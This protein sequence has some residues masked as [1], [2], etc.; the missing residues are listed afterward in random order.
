[1]KFIAEFGMSNYDNIKLGPGFE[2]N[3]DKTSL[4]N[5]L[6]TRQAFI[7]E[8]LDLELA[9]RPASASIR[10]LR[11]EGVQSNMVVPLIMG[12]SVFGIVFFSSIHKHFFTQQHLKLSEKLIFEISGFMNRAY[13]TKV[14]LSRITSGFSELVDQKDN[15]T[16]DHI[17][18]MVKYSVV[19]AEGLMARNIPGYKVD[20]KFVLEIE[21]NA[22][23]HDI[24]KVGIPDEILKKPGKLT[25]EE[26]EIMKT[27]VTIGSEIFRS[28]KEDLQVFESDFYK[29]AEEIA[30]SHH[31][32]WDGSGYPDG[33]S[34]SEIPLSARIVAIADV[35][36]ALTSKRHYKEPFGFE[37][38]V[39]IIKSSA[40]S[41]LDPIIVEIFLERLEQ[42]RAIYENTSI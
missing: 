38:S 35:F 23:S 31:E 9:H 20:R 25:P 37:N 17:E 42:F 2:V 10:L 22:A 13:F 32:R 33:L 29:F 3:F 27:H 4:T 28:F 41:H 11:E 39:E 24:G 34:D 15:E 1:K 40:G 18:R 36:D 30:R 5:I 16:G 21:R 12:D 7:T 14:I 19:I 6:Q 8:D 26:W